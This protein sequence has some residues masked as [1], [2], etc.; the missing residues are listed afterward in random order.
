M[1]LQKDD[2]LISI[3]KP[4][5]NI[6]N[7]Q[8]LD[9]MQRIK[10]HREQAE[11]FN[12]DLDLQ[13]KRFDVETSTFGKIALSF[14]ALSWWKQGLIALGIGAIATLIGTAVSLA[15]VIALPIVALTVYCT[16]AYLFNDYSQSDE[17]RF[18]QLT[19][20]LVERE[21]E[22]KQSILELQEAESDLYTLIGTLKEFDQVNAEI[23]DRTNAQA[24]LLEEK[25]KR[26][27]NAVLQFEQLKAAFGTH[28]EGMQIVENEFSADLGQIT[29][30]LA[31]QSQRIKQNTDELEQS[32]LKLHEGIEALK[33]MPLSFTAEE[34]HSP[35]AGFDRLTD[36]FV[37]RTD[38][39][40][41]V[42]QERFSQAD[43]FLGETDTFILEMTHFLSQRQGTNQHLI[44]ANQDRDRST[45][46]RPK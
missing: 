46:I 10:K 22:M 19:E 43:R 9:T 36:G 26:Y 4:E 15:W 12:A 25:V 38:I 3:E 11:L 45:S 2:L 31:Q 33:V 27:E 28:T 24:L 37:E 13:R 20:G 40:L 6:L 16:F 17:N 34:S 44:A 21:K 7:E 5:S 39:D 35:N 18:T 32:T 41:Q 14:A 42:E 1:A 30:S 8:F 23:V 29:A